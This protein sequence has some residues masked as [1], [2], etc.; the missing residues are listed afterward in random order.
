MRN[1]PNGNGNGRN[2]TKERKQKKRD[3]K[4]SHL[5]GIVR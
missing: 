4:I 2:E 1:D 3:V 5:A